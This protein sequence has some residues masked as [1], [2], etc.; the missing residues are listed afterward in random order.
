MASA[1]VV[2]TDDP[3]ST[4]AV[5]RD[6]PRVYKTQIADA[7]LAALSRTFG[8]WIGGPV[9]VEMEGLGRDPLFD[10]V[11]TSRTVGW[12]T[13]LYP[14]RAEWTPGRVADGAPRRARAAQRHAGSPGS[15]TAPCAIWPL[16]LDD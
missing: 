13:T 8:E 12:F 9:L 1:A 11:D 10:D 3:E 2:R 4:Q 7:F 15:A 14:V 16:R 5:L 6:L